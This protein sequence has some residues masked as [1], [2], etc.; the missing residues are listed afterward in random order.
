M[1]FLLRLATGHV[2]MCL[3][4]GLNRAARVGAWKEDKS[5][6]GIGLADLLDTFCKAASNV[7]PYGAFLA[8]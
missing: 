7:G 2:L 3:C 8:A 4:S 1:R 6:S 5:L